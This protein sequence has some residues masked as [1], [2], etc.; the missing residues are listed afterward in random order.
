MTASTK[1]RRGP[2]PSQIAN[3][4]ASEQSVQEDE[5]GG[6]QPQ[7]SRPTDSQAERRLSFNEVYRYGRATHLGI[8][9]IAKMKKLT[10]LAMERSEPL[11]FM[12]AQAV[13][14]EEAIDV[15]DPIPEFPVQSAAGAPSQRA[16][17]PTREEHADVQTWRI[18]HR[19]KKTA[20]AMSAGQPGS[21]RPH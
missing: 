6:R 19:T 2:R 21:N 18:R 3:D 8:L 4:A 17:C 20:S 9:P 13:A 12:D 1:A 11:E 15:D 16:V 14:M 5:S 7:E 10:Q